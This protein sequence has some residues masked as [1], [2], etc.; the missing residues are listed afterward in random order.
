[1]PKYCHQSIYMW[2]KKIYLY[3]DQTIDEMK[4]IENKQNK[5]ISSRVLSLDEITVEKE[6][7][8]NLKKKWNWNSEKTKVQRKTSYEY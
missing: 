6:K 7:E 3:A 5:R 8:K 1:M 4:W 2:E